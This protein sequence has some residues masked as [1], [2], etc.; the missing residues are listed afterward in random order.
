[1]LG[2]LELAPTA[3]TIV[4]DDVSQQCGEGGSIDR[5][6]LA[7]GHRAGR[8]VVVAGGDD[9]LR[10]RRDAAV[11]HEDVDVVLRG[12]QRADIAIEV[13]MGL[14]GVL[15]LLEHIGIGRVEELA[16]LLADLS[17]PLGQRIDVVVDA[18]IDHI[19]HVSIYADVERGVQTYLIS[20]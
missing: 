7:V 6:A 5:L 1:M 12:E 4:G 20:T 17:L 9:A 19:R 16:D 11:I 15:D 10:V 14:D 13:E 3:G 2:W 18:R 8:L